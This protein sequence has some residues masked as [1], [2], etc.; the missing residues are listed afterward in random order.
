MKKFLLIEEALE[1]TW[2]NLKTVLTNFGDYTKDYYEKLMNCMEYLIK[3]PEADKYKR[4]I[5]EFFENR[6]K[7]L[8]RCNKRIVIY[9][10]LIS[11]YGR[12]I[13]IK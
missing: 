13:D 11:S 5:I 3:C 7:Y 10:L 8:L 12:L 2:F 9:K 6:L 4:I 1:M